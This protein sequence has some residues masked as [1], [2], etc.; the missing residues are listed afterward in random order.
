MAGAGGSERSAV[1]VI[2]A[3]T[4]DGSETGAL[5]ARI[6]QVLDLSQRETSEVVAGSRREIVAAVESWLDALLSKPRS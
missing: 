2:R 4:E 5:R 3:W 1:L 6:T